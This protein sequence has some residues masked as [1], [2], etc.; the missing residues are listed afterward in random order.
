MFSRSFG[1]CHSTA[2]YTVCGS[3]RCPGLSHQ[4]VPLGGTEGAFVITQE[5]QLGRSSI[6]LATSSFNFLNN[7]VSDGFAR[8]AAFDSDAPC[9]DL[10]IATTFH[11]HARNDPVVVV[12]NFE[13]IRTPALIRLPQRDYAV[14]YPAANG[15]FGRAVDQA[16]STTISVSRQ[17]QTFGPF[18]VDRNGEKYRPALLR[19]HCPTIASV[20]STFFRANSTASFGISASMV[21]RTRELAGAIFTQQVPIDKLLLRLR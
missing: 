19:R 12:G 21:S 5:L 10:A 11:E 20:Q 2:C 17:G 16:A 18:C 13:S 15:P 6:G 4:R 7:H 14:V 8:R 1:R 9:K 3:A